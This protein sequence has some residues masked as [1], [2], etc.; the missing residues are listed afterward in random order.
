MKSRPKDGRRDLVKKGLEREG[1]CILKIVISKGEGVQFLYVIIFLQGIK[2]WYTTLF[3]K[4]PPP[5]WDVIN[6]RSLRC[7]LR[8]DLLLINSCQR[9]PLALLSTKSFHYMAK[10][11][12]RQ[13]KANPAFWLA[14]QA[15]KM[16]PFCPLGISSVGPASKRSL[17]GHTINSLLTKLVWSRWLNIGLL[18]CIF[19]DRDHG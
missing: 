8:R 14:A 9:P 19:V 4:P 1:G 2:F 16:G 5:F 12:G 17:F 6:D 7:F 18:F 13:D 11:T 15:N 3:W 10:S